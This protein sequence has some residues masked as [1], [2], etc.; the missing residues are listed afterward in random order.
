MDVPPLGSPNG[1]T[2]VLFHGNNFAGFYFGSTIDAIRREGF[3]AIAPDQMEAPQKTFPPL[4][5]FLK[6]GLAPR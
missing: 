6:E 4:V 2:V 1:Y 5:A 3:R